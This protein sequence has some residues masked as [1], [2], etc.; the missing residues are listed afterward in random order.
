[1]PDNT[2]DATTAKAE[3]INVPKKSL[4]GYAPMAAAYASTPNLEMLCGTE[5]EILV[6][7]TGL[8]TVGDGK[9]VV[10]E[11]RI[12]VPGSVTSL[13]EL[14][15]PFDVD[16]ELLEVLDFVVVVEVIGDTDGDIGGDVGGDVVGEVG[17]EFVVDPGVG[18]LWSVA[19][20]FL[21]A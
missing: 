5:A 20:R 21:E 19:C 3:L 4:D 18:V 8:S 13:T 1:M 16:L 7:E 10:E 14:D 2:M 17:G 6:N 12:G 9:M 15:K 11:G